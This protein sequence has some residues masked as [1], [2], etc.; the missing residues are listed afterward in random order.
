[1]LQEDAKSKLVNRLRRLEGQVRAIEKM[2]QDDAYCVDTLTQVSAAIG[3]LQKVGGI[4][5]ENHL[6]SCVSEAIESEGEE[7]NRKVEELVE[8]FRKYSR[9]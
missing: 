4:V 8:V 1:M 9:S 5:L 3:A 2:V 7:K 6:K